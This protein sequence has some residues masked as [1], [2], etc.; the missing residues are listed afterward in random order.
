MNTTPE[1]GYYIFRKDSMLKEFDHVVG[2]VK[3]VIVRRYG[4]KF[5]GQIIKETRAQYEALIPKIP[6]IGKKNPL[7]FNLVASAWYLALY[8]VLK[9]R[10]RPL[11]EIGQLS[12]EMYDAWFDMFPGFILRLMGLWRYTGIYMNRLEAAAAKSQKRAYPG[13]FV[14]TVIKGD[15][16]DFDWGV[17]YLEC[18]ICKFY[19]EQGAEEFLPY[20]CPLDAVISERTGLGLTRK[21]TLAEGFDRCEFRFKKGGQT[22]INK[23]WIKNI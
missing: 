19:K 10:D 11:D 15:G 5:A 4:Q 18:A 16:K 6:Y 7:E 21:K 3:K 2:R 20:L 14:Y 13:D 12:Y 17:D 22:I 9:A 8:R 1:T 23:P